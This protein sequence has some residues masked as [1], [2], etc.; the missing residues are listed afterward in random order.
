[1]MR[2]FYE[3]RR[4]LQNRNQWIKEAFYEN[5]DDAEEFVKFRIK[6][7]KAK[8][9]PDNMNLNFDIVE[10]RFSRPAPLPR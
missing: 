2:I 7:L 5:R 1:M 10:H 4:Q 3:V 8:R 9:F 6:Y